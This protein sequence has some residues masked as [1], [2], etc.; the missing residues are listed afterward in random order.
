[1]GESFES[2]LDFLKLLNKE[3]GFESESDEKIMKVLVFID[4][5][6]SMGKTLE[7]TKNSVGAMFE[8]ARESL[9]SMNLSEDLILMKIACYRNYSSMKDKLLE[10][11][12]GWTSNL[13][14]IRGFLNDL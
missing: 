6:K 7:K 2:L 9:R 1:V 8:K 13:L 14:T 11:S 4:G 12:P 3:P 10:V 5:T